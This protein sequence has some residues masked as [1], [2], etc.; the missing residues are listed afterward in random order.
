MTY[1]G[2]GSRETP[3]AICEQMTRIARY[4][5]QKGYMLF[6][7]GA[8]G[9]DDAFI[10]G[11]IKSTL[12]TP[13]RVFRG[14]IGSTPTPDAFALAKLY[15]P[16]W[17]KCSD[18][19]KKAHARNSHIILGHDLW[20]PV[21]FVVAYAP[22]KDGEPQGGTA[23]GIRV[24]TAYKIPIFNFNIKNFPDEEYERFIKWQRSPPK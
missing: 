8:E 12:F 21:D 5:Y 19:A 1:A 4:L 17:H 16:A 20:N 2:I 9:A 15:H 10:H 24:A 13:N 7:G 3:K 23:Q 22:M 18:F 6:T 14:Y 11:T